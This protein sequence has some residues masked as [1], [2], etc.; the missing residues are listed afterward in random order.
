MAR[1][2]VRLRYPVSIISVDDKGAVGNALEIGDA[3]TLAESINLTERQGY[4]VRD[5]GDGGHCRLVQTGAEDIQGFI[6]T[7]YPVE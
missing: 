6:I 2:G 1:C 5:E 7:V 4:R 3:E